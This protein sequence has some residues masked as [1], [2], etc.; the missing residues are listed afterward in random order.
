MFTAVS[1]GVLGANRLSK[2]VWPFLKELIFFYHRTNV[3][4]NPLRKWLFFTA[5]QGV[6][7]RGPCTDCSFTFQTLSITARDLMFSLS[8]QQSYSSLANSPAAILSVYAVQPA[9]LP[10][11][12]AILCAFDWLCFHTVPIPYGTHKAWI[13]N[14]NSKG[15]K[16][17]WRR[18][19]N[20]CMTAPYENTFHNV[21]FIT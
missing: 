17:W 10:Q 2:F 20:L 15:G 11:S 5:Q 4:L 9:W 18:L 21:Q 12:V 1:F 7:Y 6:Y 3:V 13:F 19:Y 8:A 16:A 14:L